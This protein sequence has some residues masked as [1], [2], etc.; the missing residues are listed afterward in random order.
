MAL[1]PDFP[2][3]PYQV[4]PPDQRWFPAAE[5]LGDTAFTLPLG[6]D[7]MKRI[8]PADLGRAATTA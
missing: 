8:M 7:F 2:P 3:S 5:T 1:Q 4:L 6:G